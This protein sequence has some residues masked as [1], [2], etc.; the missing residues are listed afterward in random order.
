MN[1]HELLEKI[2]VSAN[3][4]KASAGRILNSCLEAITLALKNDQTVSLP[5]FGTFS[6]KRREARV[7]RNPQTGHAIDIPAAN[8]PNFKVSKALKEAV[9]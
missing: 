4:T 3:V 9:N 1:K 6:V 5:G 8:V 2:A 7:G